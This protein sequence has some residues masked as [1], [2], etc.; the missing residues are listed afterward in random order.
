MIY[1]SKYTS[2]S[3]ISTD[4]FFDKA[5]LYFSGYSK[6]ATL[7]VSPLLEDNLD[8]IAIWEV[9]SA[10]IHL[11]KPMPFYQLHIIDE[12]DLYEAEDMTVIF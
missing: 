1:K 5:H 11:L 12:M 7:I 8:L 4:L 9:F 6:F 3:Y 2:F 10:S